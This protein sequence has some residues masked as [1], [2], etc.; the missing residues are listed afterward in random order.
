MEMLQY[1]LHVAKQRQGF[2][3]FGSMYRLCVVRMISFFMDYT[4]TRESPNPKEEQEYYSCTNY[5][6]YVLYVPLY[7]TGPV[8]TF[9]N[10]IAR[11]LPSAE[12]ESESRKK[13]LYPL[14]TNSEWWREYF[15]SFAK[16]IAF[17][18]V[19]DVFTHF[20]YFNNYYYQANWDN[21]S[22]T[23]C[24]VMIYT[25]AFLFFWGRYY[26]LF[27]FSRLWA[28]LDC[29]HYD[30]KVT[31]PDEEPMYRFWVP[32]DMPL[33][34]WQCTSLNRYSL[35][36]WHLSLADWALRYIYV[37]LGG[38]NR[39][40]LGATI[41][42]VF[43]GTVHG[44]TL[45]MLSLGIIKLYVPFLIEL[46]FRMWC[47]KHV[48]G[49][50]DL[51][52]ERWLL[53]LLNAFWNMTIVAF[54]FLPME[55]SASELVHHTFIRGGIGPF[56]FMYVFFVCKVVLNY[57]AEDNWKSDSIRSYGEWNLV[58]KMWALGDVQDYQSNYNPI[59]RHITKKASSDEDQIL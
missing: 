28:N 25:S 52:V 6:F 24:Y 46:A 40:Y 12:V 59:R 22:P 2:I 18:L 36:T 10:F 56:M 35:E 41:C 15:K 34:S 11:W 48:Q 4:W 45:E 30:K 16:F 8:C 14:Y 38:T 29:S 27:N 37:P 50:T 3:Q 44:I 54:Q 58:P 21:M 31:G 33:C 1:I 26:C 20:C 9:N 5:L 43:S 53:V 13:E 7:L 19:L 17:A 49:K 57:A 39:A 55:R 42:F 32:C 47:V 23:E 51:Y